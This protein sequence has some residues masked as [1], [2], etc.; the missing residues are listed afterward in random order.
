L[1]SSE[2]EEKDSTAG[3]PA[4]RWRLPLLI[5]GAVIALALVV[6]IGAYQFGTRERAPIDKVKTQ[7][8]H[9][10]DVT[11]GQGILD[12]IK[13]RGIKVVSEGFKP[14]WGAEQVGD[15][16]W[17]VSYVFEVGRQSHWASWRVNTKTGSVKPA[18]DLARQV[19][20]GTP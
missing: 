12:F 10:T 13:S 11:I 7:A 19:S 9:G 3:K 8:I 20:E 4:S 15:H 16:E 18:N 2:P 14:T 1:S 5:A 17:V 6:G